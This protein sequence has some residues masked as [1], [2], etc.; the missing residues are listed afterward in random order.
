MCRYAMTPEGRIDRAFI[1]LATIHAPWICDPPLAAEID[2][3]T[4]NEREQ[5]DLDEMERRL[6]QC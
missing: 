1:K 5:I 4:K 2:A 3:I 6:E